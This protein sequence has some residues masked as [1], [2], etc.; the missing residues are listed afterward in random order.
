MVA[1]NG[2]AADRDGGV[3]ALGTPMRVGCRTVDR[4]IRPA[5]ADRAADRLDEALGQ[6]LQANLH[7]KVR[8]SGTRR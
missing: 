5:R 2:A 1:L 6:G 8:A 3:D 4:V 7:A